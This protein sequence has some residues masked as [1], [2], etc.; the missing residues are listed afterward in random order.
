MPAAGCRERVRGRVLC[1]RDP[2]PGPAAER[3][4][5]GAG[6]GPVGAQRVPGERRSGRNGPTLAPSSPRSWSSLRAPGA[7]HAVPDQRHRQVRVPGRLLLRRRL[8]GRAVPRAGHVRV[9]EQRGPLHR[10]LPPRPDARPRPL[11]VPQRRRLRRD[12]CG[13][14]AGGQRR[15]RVVAGAPGVPRRVGGRYPAR[16]CERPLLLPQ[17]VSLLPP[18]VPV[19]V[20]EGTHYY[21]LDQTQEGLRYEGGWDQG[22]QHGRGTLAVGD[23]RVHS[24]WLEGRNDQVGM[25]ARRPMQQRPHLASHP[26]HRWT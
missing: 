9:E 13:R 16:R 22:R 23:Y 1:G 24:T 4:G 17:P 8:G 11:R 3:A 15:V 2:R 26:L 5:R 7:V 25:T 20:A 18:C 6:P 10:L 19:C 21:D 14:Q 12:L